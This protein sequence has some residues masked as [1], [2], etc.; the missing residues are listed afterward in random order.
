MNTNAVRPHGMPIILIL[1]ISELEVGECLMTLQMDLLLHLL[2]EQL[3][4]A[5]QTDPL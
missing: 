3:W 1:S 4:Q 2:T 5:L